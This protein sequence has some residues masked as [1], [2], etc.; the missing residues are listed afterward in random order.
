MADRRGEFVGFWCPPEL[1]RKLQEAARKD[2]RDVS[3][4]CIK[5]LE[6]SFGETKAEEKAEVRQ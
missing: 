4:E 5:R 1:K 2:Y 6:E 3:K